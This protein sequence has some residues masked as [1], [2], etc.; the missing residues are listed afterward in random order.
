MLARINIVPLRSHLLGTAWGPRPPR[1]VQSSMARALPLT[2]V[3]LTPLRKCR[4][5]MG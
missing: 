4:A 5:E 1:P 2:I 3:T